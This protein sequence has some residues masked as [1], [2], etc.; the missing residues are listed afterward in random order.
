MKSAIYVSGPINNASVPGDSTIQFELKIACESN[1]ISALMLV[2][3]SLILTLHTM[4]FGTSVSSICSKSI[5]IPILLNNIVAH[6][7][8][9]IL[10]CNQSLCIIFKVVSYICV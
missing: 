3:I 4:L 2:K 7:N 10:V 5:I 6:V 9:F 1:L 8:I